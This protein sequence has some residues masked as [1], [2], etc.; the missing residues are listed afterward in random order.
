MPLNF[1]TSALEDIEAI[2]EYLAQFSA[3][4]AQRFVDG[5]F[6]RAERLEDFPQLGR[7][8]PELRDD[9]VRELLYGQYRIIYRLRENGRIYIVSVQSGL[10]PLRLSL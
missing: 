3:V 9:T 8:V 4:A 10:R 5:V 7:V 1:L 6:M 2:R